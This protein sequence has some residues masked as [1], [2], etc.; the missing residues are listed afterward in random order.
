MIIGGNDFIDK[1]RDMIADFHRIFHEY[2][3]FSDELRSFLSDYTERRALGEVISLGL[4]DELVRAGIGIDE[5]MKQYL[6]N[7]SKL[8]AEY[9]SVLEHYNENSDLNWL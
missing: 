3:V 7:I 4:R 8:I 5:N 1:N 2:C 9:Q 6:E